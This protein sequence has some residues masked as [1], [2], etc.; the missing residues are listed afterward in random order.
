M[1]HLSLYHLEEVVGMMIGIEEGLVGIENSVIQRL[2]LA[3]GIMLKV[4]EVGR[5]EV[6]GGVG[7]VVISFD[8]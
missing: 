6:V 2:R 7:E 8:H 5:V 4:E 3:I 1:G